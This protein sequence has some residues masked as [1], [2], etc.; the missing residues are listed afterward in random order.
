MRAQLAIVGRDAERAALLDALAAAER[1]RKT[2]VVAVSGEPGIGK[3]TLLDALA[4]DGTVDRL[5]R[6]TGRAAE[7][8]RSL[9]FAIVQDAVDPYL[10]TLDARAI[11]RLTA[12]PGSELGS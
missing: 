3:S 10:R 12:G 7:Y 5:T 8:E 2:M 11:H 6:L 4:G 1:G 9:P